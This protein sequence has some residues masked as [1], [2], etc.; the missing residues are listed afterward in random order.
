[1]SRADERNCTHRGCNGASKRD[2]INAIWR[3]DNG[4]GTDSLKLLNETIPVISKSMESGGATY[5]SKAL[6][7][8][9]HWQTAQAVD[10]EWS[11]RG[12][13]WTEC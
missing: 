3:F 4:P 10:T 6:E 2:R 5:G 1:M 13:S 12:Q 11:C 8:S 7:V 9:K